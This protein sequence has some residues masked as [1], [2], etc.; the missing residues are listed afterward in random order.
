MRGS[1]HLWGI[2]SGEA[3]VR[4]LLSYYI[5]WAFISKIYPSE[6]AIVRT[7]ANISGDKQ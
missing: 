4:P 2:L 3:Y 5:A 6:E 7:E 1:E